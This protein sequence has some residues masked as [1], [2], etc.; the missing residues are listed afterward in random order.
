M[1]YDLKTWSQAHNSDECG[2]IVS[3]I[4]IRLDILAFGEE[5]INKIKKKINK[6]KFG[7]KLFLSISND[8]WFDAINYI[9]FQ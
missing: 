9:E 3:R 2:M 1:I 8:N 5:K 7:P 4:Y 6:R